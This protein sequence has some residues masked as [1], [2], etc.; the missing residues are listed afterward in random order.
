MASGL[1]V[2][3]TPYLGFPSV[4]GE[5]HKHYLLSDFD[6]ML[7]AENIDKLLTDLNTRAQI[8]DSSLQH[9]RNELH[10]EKSIQLYASLYRELASK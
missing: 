10:L 2:V 4:F 5:N 3:V 8:V 6:E 7:I 1:P 9:V